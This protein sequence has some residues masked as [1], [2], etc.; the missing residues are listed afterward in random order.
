MRLL[1]ATV[2]VA[3]F[4]LATTT[5]A[6]P[7]KGKAPDDPPPL[8]DRP[9]DAPRP[10]REPRPDD[11]PPPSPGKAGPRPRGDSPAFPQPVPGPNPAQAFPGASGYGGGGI[12]V[13]P[14]A[15]GW[16]PSAFGG[17]MR[18]G[19]G[20]IPGMPGMPGHY[21]EAPPDDPEMRELIKQDAELEQQSMQMAHRVREASGDERQRL[22]ESLAETEIG[23]AHV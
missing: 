13:R 23:R 20:M 7:P 5:L 21:G 8:A 15:S 6:Q 12:Y 10:R 9:P 3:I 17:G 19:G 14:G 1:I 18:G 16:P 2:F 4:A 22:R 11:E